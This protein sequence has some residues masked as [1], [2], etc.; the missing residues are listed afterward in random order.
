[1]KA[2]LTALAMVNGQ[3]YWLIGFALSFMLVYAP[4]PT[5]GSGT[6]SEGQLSTVYWQSLHL[7]NAQVPLVSLVALPQAPS[8]LRSVEISVQN[9]AVLYL[10]VRSEGLPDHAITVGHHYFFFLQQ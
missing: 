6:P 10:R 5:D 2:R 7:F 1:M 8:G 3:R 9:C 4:R